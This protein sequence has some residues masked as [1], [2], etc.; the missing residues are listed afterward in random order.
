MP[1]LHI[2]KESSKKPNDFPQISHSG[3]GTNK[4]QILTLKTVT[5]SFTY[6]GLQRSRDFSDNDDLWETHVL[7]IR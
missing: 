4:S 6:E 1:I 5:P 2:V 3:R 7:S